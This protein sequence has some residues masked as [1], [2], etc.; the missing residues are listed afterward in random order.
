MRSTREGRSS[1]NRERRRTG[2][3]AYARET[4]KKTVQKLA[5]G[6]HR[7]DRTVV[8]CYHSIH[9]SKGIS[10][11]DPEG[12]EENLAWIAENCDVI[13]FEDAF[14]EPADPQRRPR[15]A[16]T[17][18]DGFRDNHEFA[19]PILDRYSVTATFFVTTGLIDR[20]PGVVAH[21][22]KRWRA[23]EDEMEPMSWTQIDEMRSAGM[24][25]GAHTVTHPNLALLDEP[26]AL[27]ELRVSKEILEGR[28]G[29]RILCVAYP[30]GKPRV[31][32]SARTTALASEAGYEFGAVILYRS[33]RATD[34]PLAI[35]RFF[36]GHETRAS[37]ETK[38]HGGLDLLGVWQA[39]APV[40]ALRA[41]HPQDFET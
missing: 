35:P 1:G 27:E 26:K 10:C 14:A 30:F 34:H 25:I 36:A 19:L 41:V 28:L 13:R 29:G 3:P 15:V 17:F 16:I 31:H 4:A 20:V 6:I 38:I 9:P 33:V 40:F 23:S 18:D 2:L 11:H 32:V 37:L 5:G 24:T 22:A 21:M 39:K 8:L 12:F 7:E